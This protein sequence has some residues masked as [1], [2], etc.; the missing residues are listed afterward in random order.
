MMMGVKY[1]GVSY[2]TLK[3]KYYTKKVLTYAHCGILGSF[4]V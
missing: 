1:L 4:S 3:A 2:N